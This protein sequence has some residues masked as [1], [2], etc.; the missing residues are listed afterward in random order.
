MTSKQDIIKGLRRED[1]E[2]ITG[3]LAA[4]L[5]INDLEDPG[6]HVPIEYWDTTEQAL[7]KIL[8]HI[9]TR[10]NDPAILAKLASRIQKV[11]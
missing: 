6:S 7:E 9:Q 1:P 10:V 11:H 5:G 3:W 8:R 4:T 2:V